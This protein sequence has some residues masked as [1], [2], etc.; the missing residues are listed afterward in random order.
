MY[1]LYVYEDVVAE[2]YNWTAL[3][4]ARVVGLPLTL[5]TFLPLPL[6]PQ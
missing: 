6:P 5:Y 2:G 4:E 1:S 3:I